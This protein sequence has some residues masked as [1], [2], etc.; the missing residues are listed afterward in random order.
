MI[1]KVMHRL[2]YWIYCVGATWKSGLG[3]AFAMVFTCCSRS[4]TQS[5]EN[6]GVEHLNTS[7]NHE[8][9][10]N[11]YTLICKS[12]RDVGVTRSQRT[13]LPTL[14]QTHRQSLMACHM[15]NVHL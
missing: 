10:T 4:L 9:L 11:V 3:P 1:W 8:L 7:V 13:T 6:Q 5:C 12:Q 15:H 2:Y 14:C